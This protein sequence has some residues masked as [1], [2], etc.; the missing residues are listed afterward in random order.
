MPFGESRGGDTVQTVSL[1]QYDR[2]DP[3][4]RET[5]SA[6]YRRENLIGSY[7]T[8]S[9]ANISSD[10]A[11]Y[12]DPEYDLFEDIEGYEQWADRFEHSFNPK[13]TAA[14]KAD[15]DR[16]RDTEATL[17]AAGW[18]GMGLSMLAGV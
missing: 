6:A 12:I 11:N 4:F 16:D 1:S 14:I 17:S 9:V 8:S 5:L 10:E 7:M 15:I 13:M 18:T 3:S 2:P